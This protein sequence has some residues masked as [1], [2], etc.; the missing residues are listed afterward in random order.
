MILA[1]GL[2]TR[3]SEEA[4]LRLPPAHPIAAVSQEAEFLELA[5]LISSLYDLSPT[6]S[7]I[8]P[9][10]SPNRYTADPAPNVNMRHELGI[11]PRS[12]QLQIFDSASGLRRLQ[13]R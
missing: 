11:E 9:S 5:S 13:D 7:T 6:S 12:M 3:I 4:H 1:G 8:D 2:G 10:L